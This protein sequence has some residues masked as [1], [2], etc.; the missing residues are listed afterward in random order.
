MWECFVR[1]CQ[2]DCRRKCHSTALLFT[3]ELQKTGVQNDICTGLKQISMP[4]GQLF[5]V[6]GTVIDATEIW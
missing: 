1:I 6:V 4:D 3:A 2:F 5:T